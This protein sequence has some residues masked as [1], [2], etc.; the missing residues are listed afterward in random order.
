LEKHPKH[1]TW[2]DVFWFSKIDDPDYPQ[3]A[4]YRIRIGIVVDG[5]LKI[6]DF[7]GLL[8][9][10]MIGKEVKL[11]ELKEYV[12]ENYPKGSPSGLQDRK[13]D[14]V[15]DRIIPTLSRDTLAVGG[16]ITVQIPQ[17]NDGTGGFCF[18]VDKF[19]VRN[20]EITAIGAG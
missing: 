4:Q 18:N 6:T 11:A 5:N 7:C 9:T 1:P 20:V 19:T 17:S 12:K 3:P 13:Y 2:T 8:P 14:L 15:K 10:K 16:P